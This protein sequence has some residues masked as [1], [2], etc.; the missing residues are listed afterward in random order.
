M[1]FKLAGA[2]LFVLII[3]AGCSGN[4]TGEIT[5]EEPIKIKERKLKEDIEI[6]QADKEPELKLHE[7]LLP[8]KNEKDKKL[9]EDYFL[10]IFTLLSKDIRQQIMDLSIPED[11]KRE[12][13]KELAFLTIEEQHKYVESIIHLYR[14]IP[15]KLIERI[16]K[17]PNVKPEYYVK[18]AQQLKFMDSDDQVKFIQFLEKNA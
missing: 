13:L 3:I 1:R 4:I 16:K 10:K 2:I 15:I 14:E 8:V 5:K 9:V 7:S 6:P 11:Q 18:I 17:L 12:L